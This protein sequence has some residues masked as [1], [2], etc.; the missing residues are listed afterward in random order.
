M[1]IP[2]TLRALFFSAATSFL[3]VNAAQANFHLMQIE[4]AIGGVFDGVNVDASAQ[5]IQLRMR[6][7]GQNLVSAASLWV[8]DATGANR[9]LLV[10]MGANVGNAAAGDRVLIVSSNFG[11]YLS[12][13][14][15]RDF[16]W[17]I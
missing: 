1:K 17:P 2:P 5:A 15:T 12:P 4:E 11:K 13:A 3:G 14:L 9:I 6:S 16:P 10:N 7:S 8:A